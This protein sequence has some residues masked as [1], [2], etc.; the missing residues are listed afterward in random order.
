MEN[1]R[2]KGEIEELQ[3]R[4]PGLEAKERMNAS[5]EH[6]LDALRQ[7]LE[8]EA[9][10]RME[11]HEARKALQRSLESVRQEREQAGKRCFELTSRLEES[12]RELQLANERERENES[13][14]KRLRTALRHREE[15]LKALQELLR[16]AEAKAL[17]LTLEAEKT[18]REAEEQ[19]R[20]LE[21]QLEEQR[22][23]VERAAEEGRRKV[24]EAGKQLRR[25]YEARL[26]KLYR[27]LVEREKVEQRLRGVIESGRRPYDRCANDWVDP[28]ARFSLSSAPAGGV[29]DEDLSGLPRTSECQGTCNEIWR[30][31]ERVEKRLLKALSTGGRAAEQA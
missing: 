29:F 7:T 27:E 18:A 1:G 31:G 19:R 15:E 13:E 3:R 28:A 26:S 21:Q 30:M 16:E 6:D 9:K 17:Q 5:L 25:R 11:D 8:A 22:R 10:G 2:M 12:L 23:S 20:S 24:E 14:E 4:I